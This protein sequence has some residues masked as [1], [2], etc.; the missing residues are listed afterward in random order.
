[1][2]KTLNL[3]CCGYYRRAFDRQKAKVQIMVYREVLWAKQNQNKLVKLHLKPW[4]PQS[5][6]S[7]RSLLKK[8]NF[9][10][11]CDAFKI[12][13]KML[14]ILNLMPKLICKDLPAEFELH[15]LATTEIFPM[16]QSRGFQTKVQLM[17]LRSC[18]VRCGADD[19]P[20][21]VWRSESASKS[22]SCAFS[23]PSEPSKRRWA[24]KPSRSSGGS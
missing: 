16:R 24:R 7:G 9:C 21:P 13:H 5:T 2:T 22:S 3:S 6:Q 12:K 1:M 4:T 14:T 19:W 23:P 10:H 15:L 18:V 17:L 8:F 20:Q 11:T